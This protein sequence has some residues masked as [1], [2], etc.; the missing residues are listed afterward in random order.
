MCALAGFEA[1]IYLE[2]RHPALTSAP[3]SAGTL[4]NMK[5]DPF[6]SGMWQPSMPADPSMQTATRLKVIDEAP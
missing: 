6:S 4:A 3:Q 2:S 1:Y 5:H